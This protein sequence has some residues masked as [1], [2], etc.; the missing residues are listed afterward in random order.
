[1]YQNNPTRFILMRKVLRLYVVRI[2][3]SVG[4]VQSEEYTHPRNPEIYA[5]IGKSVQKSRRHRVKSGIPS[6]IRKSG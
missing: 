5:E 6:E 3:W 1:M 4:P 2:S